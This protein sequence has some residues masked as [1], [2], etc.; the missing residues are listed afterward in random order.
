MASLLFPFASSAVFTAKS[1][2]QLEKYS[3]ASL[4]LLVFALTFSCLFSDLCLD[5]KAK[6]PGRYLSVLLKMLYTPAKCRAV[7]AFTGDLFFL[8]DLTKLINSLLSQDL[9]LHLGLVFLEKKKKSPYTHIAPK[10]HLISIRKFLILEKEWP[11]I[12]ITHFPKLM[13]QGRIKLMKNKDL[14]G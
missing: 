10:L 8:S 2:L 5:E 6:A 1:N 13:L 3:L 4:T 11:K 7:L 12:I 14:L 9:L